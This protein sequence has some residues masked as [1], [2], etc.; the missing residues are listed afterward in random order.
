[1]Q[2]TLLSIAIVIILALVTALVG[3]LFVDWNKY[4]GQFEAEASR[5]TGLTVRI[6]GPIEARLLPTP[7]MTLQKVDISRAGAP[8][9]VQAN[10]LGI[11]FALGALV[12]G[13]WRATDVRIERAQF[14]LGLDANGR[15]EWPAPRVGFDPDAI[16]IQNLDI[17]DSRVR[18]HGITGSGV[19][20]DKF[21][22]QGELRSL[23]GPVKGAGAFVLNGQH[24]P[25]RLAV[26]R[27]GDDGAARVRL[28]VDP[29]DLP[30]IA[31]A[32]ATIT[33]EDGI[34]RFEGSMQVA[35]PVGR[36]PKGG[37]EL[38]VEPWRVTSKIKGDSRAAV[39]EQIEFQYGPDDR[40]LKLKGDARLAFGRKPQLD[41]VLS[42][43]QIDLDRMLSL[44]EAARRHPFA[45]VKAFT[46][47]IAG[48]HA[49][50]IPVKLGISV[51]QVT[52]A[53]ATL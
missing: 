17:V 35:R 6:S 14:D 48:T 22:F 25:F 51:E 52:L 16:S 13:E 7:T 47:S 41:G 36:A 31:D 24:Y 26:G 45:A 32:D 23:L 11:E 2:T 18:L 27:P 8:S 34:P 44:P 30:L 43:T 40:A 50:P 3:P 15:L 33:V 39:L 29:I 28:N 10:K 4:R 9:A 19:V 12:R 42:S 1:V 21:E 38:I 53:G 5:L 49:L 46:D 20:F 37:S